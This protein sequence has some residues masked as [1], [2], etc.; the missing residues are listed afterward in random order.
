MELCV[1]FLKRYTDL[2]INDYFPWRLMCLN[3]DMKFCSHKHG[4]TFLTVQYYCLWPFMKTGRY[5]YNLSGPSNTP[6]AGF[7]DSAV[8][9]LHT[10]PHP[11][12][13]SRL[14][15]P[16]SSR[17]MADI[18]LSTSTSIFPRASQ[19]SPLGTLTNILHPTRL[20]LLTKR[21]P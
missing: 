12:G 16:F 14:P 8:A 5:L 15:R 7:Q 20:L 17:V 6:A 18:L 9:L 1:F 19:A 21:G 2:R 11:R 3:G 10:A 4:K 13:G